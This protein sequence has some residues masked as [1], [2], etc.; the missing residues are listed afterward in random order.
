VAREQATLR[1]RKREAEIAAEIEVARRNYASAAD[2]LHQQHDQI[3]PRSAEV[4]K[5]I[6]LAYEKGGAS[7]L[8]LLSAQRTDNEVRLA[9][10]Q[11][12]AET[13]RALATLKAAL[14]F[15][16]TNSPSH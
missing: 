14:N 5:T 7:L 11:A 13:A 6:S 1:L 2:R 12:A 3:L 16:E 9:D 15:S 4:R 8:D 10:A